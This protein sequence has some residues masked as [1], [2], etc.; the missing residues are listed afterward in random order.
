[1]EKILITGASGLLGTKVMKLAVNSYE[2]IPTHNTRSL[3]ENSIKMN[4]TSLDEVFRVIVEAK[5]DVTLH[6]AAETGVDKCEVYKKDAWMVNVEGTKNVIEACNKINAKLIY[7]ST[8]YIFDGEKGFYVEED[9]PNPVN[10]YGLTKLKG[11]EFVR[12]CCKDYAIARA[13]VLYGWHHWKVN[14]ATWVIAKL[15]YDKQITV[16]DDHYNSPTFADNFAEILLEMVK[17]DLRGVYHVAGSERISRYE[18]ALKI[19]ET[20]SLDVNLVKPIKMSELMVWVA[21]RPKDS[22]LCID[23]I[24]KRLKTRLL[25]VQEGLNFMKKSNENN[26]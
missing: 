23:T 15:R 9:E 2:V 22:S 1:M 3:F 13:S 21:K 11:E 7:V 8:D 19:A 18:F 6:T 25:N 5:P 20:F 24:R 4:I 12:K 16:V 14:F 17:K 10:Y 26:I